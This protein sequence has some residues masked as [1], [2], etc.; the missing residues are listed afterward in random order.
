[1][2]EASVQRQLDAHDERLNSHSGE[3]HS[4][5]LWRAEVKG[6]LRTLSIIV[7]LGLAVPGAMAAIVGIVLLTEKG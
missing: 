4:L 5:Q 6:S 7:G 2:V 3:I 1:M